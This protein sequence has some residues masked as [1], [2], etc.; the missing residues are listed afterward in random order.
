M[1]ELVGI[2]KRFG[3]R[4]AVDGVTFT[5]RPGR[6]TGFLGPNGAGKSTTLRILLGL[7]RPSSGTATID[8]QP[9][10]R[11]HRPD[12]MVAGDRGGGGM[13]AP[14][15]GCAM[16]GLVGAELT[17]IRTLPAVW[18]AL[19]IALLAN[20]TVRVARLDALTLTPVYCPSF[21]RL[22]PHEAS[23]SFLRTPAVPTSALSPTA[24]LLVL[25]AWTAGLLAAAWLTV[26][27]RDA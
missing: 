11:G 26:R 23:L 21:V 4:L 5:V 2:T 10:V 13:G 15:A 22:L 1:I 18:V 16:S 25:A 14:P 9:G 12:R 8:R 20:A 19:A 27:R 6:V 3:G 24:G 7:D 17:K